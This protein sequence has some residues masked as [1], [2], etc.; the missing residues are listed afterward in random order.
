MLLPYSSR[1]NKLAKIMKTSYTY[2]ISKLN[3][4]NRRIQ[5]EIVLLL[6]IGISWLS[7]QRYLQER[8]I[9]DIDLQKFQEKS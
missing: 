1:M 6:E 2:R 4:M 5:R 9:I 8:S 3:R 7:R